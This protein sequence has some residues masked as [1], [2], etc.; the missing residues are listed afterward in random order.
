MN[1]ASV[2]SLPE[3]IRLDMTHCVLSRMLLKLALIIKVLGPITNDL[4]LITT[5]EVFSGLP[6]S[7]LNWAYVRRAVYFVAY[8][9]PEV[10]I[11]GVFDMPKIS[12]MQKHT[13]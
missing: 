11:F 12:E 1:I 7:F 5:L 10:L 4:G 3:N 13:S 9:T 6:L 2:D 8:G